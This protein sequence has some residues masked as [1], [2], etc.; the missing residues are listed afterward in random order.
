MKIPL[1]V[2]GASG[3]VGAYAIKLAQTSNIHLIIAVAGRAQP[4]VETLITREKGDII[5]DY[6]GHEAIVPA[7]RIP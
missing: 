2:Y 5:I 7:L 4:F 6:H 3:A 1:I